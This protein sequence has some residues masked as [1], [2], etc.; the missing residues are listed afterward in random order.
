[1]LQN[2]NIKWSY[3]TQESS[4]I[5]FSEDVNMFL[6]LIKQKKHVEILDLIRVCC[7]EWNKWGRVVC[8]CFL[9]LFL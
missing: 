9:M 4:K 1:M 5:L 6:V 2:L 8:F 3:V 7:K